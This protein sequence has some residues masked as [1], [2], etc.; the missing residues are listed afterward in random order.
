MSSIIGVDRK[1]SVLTASS[2]S[3]LSR[4]PTIN[5]TAGC[6][7]GCVYCYTLRY[8]SHP[9]TGKI[10]VYQNTLAK[11][12]A[13]LARKRDVPRAVFFSTSSDLFQPV[14]EVLEMAHQI[15]EFLFSE[16]IGAV[17]LT[18]GQIPEETLHLLLG[19]ADRVRAQIGIT[20]LDEHVARIFEPHAPT[21]T[22]RLRQ[23]A[24]LTAGGVATQA[25]LDPV[26]P[27][28]TDTPDVL[29]SLFSAL[30]QAG[31][32][33][34]ATGVL[35]LR[36]DILRSLERRVLD[37]TVLER[38]L[39]FYCDTERLAVRAE[40]STITTLPRA[41]REEI[42]ARIQRAAEDVRIQVSICACKNPDIAR[43]TCGVG[44]TWPRHPR[45]EEQPRLLT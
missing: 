8:S 10:V 30:A 33:R 41:A 9:G 26:L 31:V 3:C 42:F 6:A 45:V 35:F 7:L 22:V 12:E 20:T 2:L 19:H 34:A 29:R 23:M 13:E 5:L 25:R 38:L 1:S 14:P 15:L 4:M 28:L 21:P 40:N 27:G 17:L 39:S 37:R 36:P 24:T 18:K 16:G 44:G 11:L 32:K 43:G